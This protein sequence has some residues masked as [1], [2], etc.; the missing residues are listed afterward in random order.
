MSKEI[1]K[2]PEKPEGGHATRLPIHLDRILGN[3]LGGLL[4]EEKR[5]WVLV[6]VTGLATG[7][8]AVALLWLLDQV[9]LLAW[10]NADDVLKAVEEGG[11]WRRL[12]VPA[13]G[14]IL[15]A[16]A[17][18]LGGRER[19]PEG[20]SGLI[21]SLVLEKGR[22]PLWRTVLKSITCI[23]A[24]GSGA[25]LGREGGLIQSGSAMGSWLGEKLRLK[26][27]H[28][29]VL[30]AAGAA[31]GVAAAYNAPIG[32][33]V[34]AMEILLGTFALD[35]F[36][37]IIISSV[38]ATFVSRALISEIHVYHVPSYVFQ[39]WEILTFLALGI[40]L[41]LV[42]VL[43]I[44]F[45][46][47]LDLLFRWRRGP[48]ILKPIIA[49]VVLGAAAVRFPDLLGNGYGTVNQVLSGQF[50]VSLEL[51]LLLPILKM[52]C[53]ALCRTG[54]VPGGLFTPSIYI[55]ALTGFGFGV[56]AAKVLPWQPSEPN[57]YALIGMGAIL[58]GTMQAPITAILL[59]FE[60]TFYNY[61]VILPLMTACIAS[62]LVSRALQKG[63]IF[64]EPL[65]R[66]GILVPE[67]LSPLWLRQPQVVDFLQKGAETLAPT[68]RFPKVVD[69]F[70]RT[71]LEHDRIYVVD[72]VG[73]YLGAISLH[74][75][76]LFIRESENLEAVIAIDLLDSTFPAVC[77]SDPLTRVIEILAEIDAERLPVLES[78]EG[79]KFLGT[80]SKRQILSAYRKGNLARIQ[81]NGS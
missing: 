7:L 70:L 8:L 79:R 45:F 26:E 22:I 19:I 16:L 41:G 71:P 17:A 56:L 27:Y 55:G 60:L 28:I 21:E 69:A 42:S 76:K 63:S 18:F 81:R 6:P 74:E 47:G 39:R 13:V 23:V 11:P 32:A 25:S 58:A 34:Y 4:P 75:I 1:R 65:R 51:L 3:F 48:S 9:H 78:P 62:S 35:L 57:A 44:R 73:A 31:G 40:F 66:K 15:V 36:G 20:T 80:V 72:P 43:F 67:P 33:S 12:A 5:Y 10:G 14:G 68:E 53:T 29:K 24:V 46:G 2:S 38:I 61:S 59:V 37:P 50:R 52:L 64:T 77:A 54:G 49:M 30:L